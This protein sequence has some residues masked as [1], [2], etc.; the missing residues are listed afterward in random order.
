MTQQEK[1]GEFWALGQSNGAPNR[2]CVENLDSTMQ[3]A[4]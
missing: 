4:R 1:A 2:V 3:P